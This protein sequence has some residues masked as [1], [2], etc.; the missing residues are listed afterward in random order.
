[1]TLTIGDL[2]N[3]EVAEEHVDRHAVRDKSDYHRHHCAGHRIAPAGMD[4]ESI[5]LLR[6]E[7]IQKLPWIKKYC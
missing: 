4:G 6:M 3:P 1:M 2:V 7:V 5:I